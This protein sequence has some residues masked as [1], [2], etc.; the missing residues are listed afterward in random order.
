MVD[1]RARKFRDPTVR[2]VRVE[3]G[4]RG[5][6]GRLCLPVGESAG[7]SVEAP[8]S[9]AARRAVASAMRSTLEAGGAGPQDRAARAG[10]TTARVTMAVTGCR[11]GGGGV[12]LSS[13]VPA[14]GWC[15]AGCGGRRRCR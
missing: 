4:R 1:V 2:V 10:V 13:C 5:V 11:R 15:G 9:R 8:G 7:G 12:G 6:E 3:L 14:A